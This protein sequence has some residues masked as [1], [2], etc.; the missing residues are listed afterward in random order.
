M[1]SLVPITKI[2][3]TIGTAVWALVLHEPYGLLILCGVEVVL[4]LL[5]RAFLEI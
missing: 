3:L 4:L 2:I 1:R 5:A